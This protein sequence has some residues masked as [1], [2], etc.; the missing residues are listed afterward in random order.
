MPQAASQ[1]RCQS[2]WQ[3]LDTWGLTWWGPQ[4]L[5]KARERSSSFRLGPAH[6]R[7]SECLS[8]CVSA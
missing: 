3:T 4:V 8:L 7:S 2:S 5:V 6:P 1:R